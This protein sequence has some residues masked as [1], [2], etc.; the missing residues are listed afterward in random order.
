MAAKGDY[1]D[2]SAEQK[3]DREGKMESEMDSPSFR[4]SGGISPFAFVSSPCRP[5]ARPGSLPGD[6]GPPRA[7]PVQGPRRAGHQVG[8]HQCDATREDGGKRA[9][10]S[11]ALNRRQLNRSMRNFRWDE[12]IPPRLTAAKKKL[13][14]SQHFLQL[15]WRLSIL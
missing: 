2:S 11:A 15:Q 8:K 9:V 14:E 7:H 10:K 6:R 1:L 5:V 3:R 12:A 13:G 4:S